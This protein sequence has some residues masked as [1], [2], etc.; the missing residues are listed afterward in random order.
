MKV[1]DY[2]LPVRIQ[3]IPKALKTRVKYLQERIWLFELQ[4]ASIVQNTIGID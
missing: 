2:L 4:Y 3:G 1:L